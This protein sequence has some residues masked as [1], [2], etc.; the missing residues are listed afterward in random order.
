MTTGQPNVYTL[1]CAVRN[2][3]NWLYK[4]SLVF[5]SCVFLYAAG[6]FERSH[7]AKCALDKSAL[8]DRLLQQ[9]TFH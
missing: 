3:P 1:T 4:L 7:T 8:T 5:E 9:Y 2:N 6:T